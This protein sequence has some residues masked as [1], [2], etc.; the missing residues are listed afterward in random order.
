MRLYVR[1]QGKGTYLGKLETGRKRLCALG[2]KSIGGGG[3][4][5][6]DEIWLIFY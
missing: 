3:G 1:V 5:E 4:G 2:G 6:G